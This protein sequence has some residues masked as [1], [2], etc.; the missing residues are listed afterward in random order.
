MKRLL[1]DRGATYRA[2]EVDGRPDL[3]A[4]L[5]ELVGR[6]SV[7][8]VFVGGAYVGGCNDGGLGGVLP[9]AE[10]GELDRLLVEA[11]ALP[12]G[13]GTPPGERAARGVDA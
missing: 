12:Q 10:S 13:K 5:A 2:E 6:A 4:G 9:L 3:R 7:P 1:E 11:A 8:A